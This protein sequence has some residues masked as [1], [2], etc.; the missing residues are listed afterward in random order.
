MTQQCV[1]P[2]GADALELGLV[3]QLGGL[4]DAIALARQAAKLSEQVGEK[5]AERGRG[6]LTYSGQAHAL[7]RIELHG[8]VPRQLSVHQRCPDFLTLSQFAALPLECL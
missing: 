3:D 5:E 2:T 4:Q 1:D 7:T 6:T 8:Q